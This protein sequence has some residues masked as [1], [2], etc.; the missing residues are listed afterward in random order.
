MRTK[1]TLVDVILSYLTKETECC[2]LYPVINKNGYGDIQYT[3]TDGKKRHCLAHRLSYEYANGNVLTSDQIILHSCD[4]PNCINPKHLRVGTHQDNVLDKVAKNRQA[5]GKANGR[6]IHGHCSKYEPVEKPKAP[7][8]SSYGRSLSQGRVKELK[9][10]ISN[11]NGKS[12]I[13]LSKELGVK[14]QTLRDI[15]CGKTYKNL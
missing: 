3:N 11:K 5:K 13:Q 15:S 10:A 1:E 2:I 4:V 14:Y 12:L 9:I 7:F 8:E 6:Y